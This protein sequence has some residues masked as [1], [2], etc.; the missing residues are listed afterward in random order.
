[1]YVQQTLLDLNDKSKGYDQSL[2][3]KESCKYNAFDVEITSSV[4]SLLVNTSN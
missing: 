4:V 2:K 1:M 3:C